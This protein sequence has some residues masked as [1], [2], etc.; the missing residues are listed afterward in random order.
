M[1]GRILSLS[2]ENYNQNVSL[3]QVPFPLFTIIRA[4]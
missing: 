4:A 3:N 1:D 2:K